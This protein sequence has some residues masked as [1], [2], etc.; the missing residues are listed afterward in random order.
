MRQR[1]PTDATFLPLS[2]FP[3]LPSLLG[4][5]GPQGGPLH[6][7]Q[8]SI[9]QEAGPLG[10]LIPD[11]GNLG[12][13]QAK[14]FTERGILALPVQQCLPVV[15]CDHC[16]GGSSVR[17]GLWG[18]PGLLPTQRSAG[19]RQGGVR[20]GSPGHTHTQPPLPAP[21]GAET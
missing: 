2:D 9:L 11:P 14:L 8:N 5:Q 4:A 10:L 3:C 15:T 16:K 13:L 19:G 17:K 12:L 20:S 18:L 21:P 6:I 7:S 1:C